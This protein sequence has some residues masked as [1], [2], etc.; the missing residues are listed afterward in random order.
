M[1]D[2]GPLNLRL[3]QLC[4]VLA[5]GIL[6]PLMAIE[7]RVQKVF[8]VAPGASLKLN[9][10]RGSIVIEDSD[11]A[12]IRADVRLDLATEDPAVADR[13]LK[14]LNLELASQDNVVTVQA[15]NP[16]ESRAR[17]TWT[18]Q[19]LD[20]AFRIYVPRTC[21]LELVTIDG[22]ITVGHVAGRVV[23]RA[24]A[25]T[26]SCRQIDGNVQA[27]MGI[28]EIVVSRCTGAVDL[29]VTRGNIRAGTIFGPAK[30]HNSSGEIEIQSARGGVTASTA[31]G[32]VTVGFPRQLEGSATIKA[33]GGN[34]TAKI[35]PATRCTVH[36]SA[37]WGRVQSSL[38]LE[39]ATGGNTRRSLIGTLNGGGPSLTLQ[40]SGGNVKLEP[41]TQFLD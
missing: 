26:I 17:F 4:L 15:H 12:Q 13:I 35:D 8:P 41:F 33:D 5:A 14:G 19:R 24:R 1:A 10:Y 39:T 37:T 11:D 40:A 3:R 16:S 23:I 30:L 7:R 22:D 21:D 38:P 18:D 2:C 29:S 31:A 32:D 20:L 6:T 28:G 25:G 36:A 9:T 27:T 34:I